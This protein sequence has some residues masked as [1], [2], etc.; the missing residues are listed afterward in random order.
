[1]KIEIT[2]RWNG[3]VLFSFDTDKIRIAL[4]AAVKSGADLK[5]ADLRGAYKVPIET[6][7]PEVSAKDSLM[8]VWKVIMGRGGLVE[9]RDDF[10]KKHLYG[11][12]KMMCETC[13]FLESI[14]AK[15]EAPKP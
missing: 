2:N 12:G 8:N 14:G 6:G 7:G 15:V 11:H 5:D 13:Y 4:Q 3:L 1:M 9:K 10:T